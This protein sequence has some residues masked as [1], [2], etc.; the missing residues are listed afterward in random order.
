MLEGDGTRR[1]GNRNNRAIEK[2][3]RR[4]NYVTSKTFGLRG[5]FI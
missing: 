2:K 1:T 5:F 3:S 4:A